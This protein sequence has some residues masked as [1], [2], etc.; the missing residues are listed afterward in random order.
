[1]SLFPTM[2]NQGKKLGK[3]PRGDFVRQEKGNPSNQRTGGGRSPS[4]HTSS[5]PNKGSPPA[6]NQ[7]KLGVRGSPKWGL[8]QCIPT[9][10]GEP[11]KKEKTNTLLFKGK[12][13]VVT[14]RSGSASK[15]M[16]KINSRGKKK[17]K[18]HSTEEKKKKRA[19]PLSL[20]RIYT[21]FQKLDKK[22]LPLTKS[23]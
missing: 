1:M 18:T 17:R 14:R 9:I 23:S 4:R 2:S 11:N 3:N 19:D 20:T 10:N 21:Q 16:C 22:P 8:K 15:C 6:K 13:N 12:K 5:G 7:R